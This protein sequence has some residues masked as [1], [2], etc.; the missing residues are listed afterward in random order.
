[1]RSLSRRGLRAPLAAAAMFLITLLMTGALRYSTLVQAEARS[2]PTLQTQYVPPVSDSYESGCQRYTDE[3]KLGRDTRYFW[4]AGNERFWRKLIGTNIARAMGSNATRGHIWDQFS[5]ETYK[6]QPTA[7]TL[8]GLYNSRDPRQPL[9]FEMPGG[10][11]GYYRTASLTSIWATAPYLHNNS[12]GTF[13]RD[14]SVSARMQA[15][16]ATWLADATE[17]WVITERRAAEW[18]R[19]GE[20]IS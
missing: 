16:V 12:L 18:Y 14:P 13:I 4:T 11:R 10:G 5:S 19:V 20:R 17:A 6:S 2:L 8:T 1:M 7:G 3:Q 15:A 9:S